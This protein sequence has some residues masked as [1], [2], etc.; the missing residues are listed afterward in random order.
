[1][2]VCNGHELPG[3]LWWAKADGTS[4]LPSAGTESLAQRAGHFASCIGLCLDDP[5]AM[6]RLYAMAEYLRGAPDLESVLPRVLEAA[7]SL[8]GADF[9]NIQLVEPATGA[10]R[11]VA[12]SGF[13]TEFLEYFAAVDDAHSA[14]GRAARECSQI[15]I[16][17]VG[18]DPDFA[19]HLDIA[20]SAGFRTVQSTP[21]A[22][23]SGRLVGMV[24]THFR[25]PRS[26]P[27]RD[28]KIMELFGDLVGEAVSRHLSAGQPARR[29]LP[30]RAQAVPEISVPEFAFYVVNRL[31]SVGIDL[32]SAKGLVG[33]GAAGER[34]AL[35][36]DEIDRAIHELRAIVFDLSDTQR[37]YESVGGLL[38]THAE[39]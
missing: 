3:L 28:L 26:L 24:S 2:P 19:P 31:R 39:R 16:A 13:S 11:I 5:A 33:D 29:D 17:D 10:L 15:V 34:I 4:V 36:T 12:Q 1:M 18:T 35:A 8:T 22:D 23:Q 37:W 9:G 21:L 7:L 30:V 6:R 14:C 32:A 27:G 38:G 25:L 20:A